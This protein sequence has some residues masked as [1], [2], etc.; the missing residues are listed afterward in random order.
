MQKLFIALGMLVVMG[1]VSAEEAAKPAEPAVKMMPTIQMGKPRA[2]GLGG[3]RQMDKDGDG[4]VSQKEFM[5]TTMERAK[6]SFARM[7]A[8]KDGFVNEEEI[9][10]ARNQAREKFRQRMQMMRQRQQQTPAPKP[11]AQETPKAE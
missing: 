5:D 2:D 4:K 7:D 9:T 10:S 8:N 11:P 3:F 1:S 6:Q